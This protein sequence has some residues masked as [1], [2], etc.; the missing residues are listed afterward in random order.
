MSG[1]R[2]DRIKSS[3]RK[4]Q[5]NYFQSEAFGEDSLRFLILWGVCDDSLTCK[6][7][8]LDT[9]SREAI[10]SPLS[11]TTSNTTNLFTTSDHGPII[12]MARMNRNTFYI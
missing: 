7:T 10:L 8:S 6:T 1:K 9:L 5:N 4:H 12:H 2:T 11:H 3:C